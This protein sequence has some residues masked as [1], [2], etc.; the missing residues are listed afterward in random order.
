MLGTILRRPGFLRSPRRR[1]LWVTVVDKNSRIDLVSEY[2]QATPGLSSFAKRRYKRAEVVESAGTNSNY[3][4]NFPHRQICLILEWLVASK[5]SRRAC[6][7]RDK[8]NAM[9]EHRGTYCVAP[10]IRRPWFAHP[11]EAGLHDTTK[12]LDNPRR[13]RICDA[14]KFPPLASCANDPVRLQPINNFLSKPLGSL[15]S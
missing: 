13:K 2:L 7:L 4:N 5:T 15:Q 9:S 14:I 12:M 10:M 8:N 6:C 11:A 3:G 1:G